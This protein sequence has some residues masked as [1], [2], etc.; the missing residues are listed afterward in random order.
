MNNEE[1]RALPAGG[2]I[3]DKKSPASVKGLHV[4]SR[5]E[6]KRSYML[7]YKTRTGRERRPKIGSFPDITIAEARRRAKI[8]L[9][10][11]ATGADPSGDWQ[12]T[13]SE[14]T[15]RDL[16][17]RTLSTHWS[18]QQYITSG[19]RS[20]V[21]LLW[22]KHI[23][24]AFGDLRISELTLSRIRTWHRSFESSPYAG[25]RSL[26][27]LSR[28][29]TTAEEDE[30]IRPGSNPCRLVKRH[31][32]RTRSRYATAEELRQLIPIL[33][34]E[35]ARHPNGVAFLWVLLLT[36][37]RPRALE[38]ATWDQLEIITRDGRRFGVLRFAGK[39][40]AKT[41]HDEVVILPEFALQ[42]VEKL[43]RRLNNLLLNSKMPTR[44][45]REIRAEMGCKDLWARDFRRTFATIAMSS[46]VNASLVGE[47]LNHRST[48]TT[49]IYA[50]LNDESRVM[51]ATQTAKMIE[52][53]I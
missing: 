13:R 19:Y 22:N 20:D 8:I 24:P 47:L 25:N 11:V 15:I 3:W 14:P 43:P 21:I 26:S 32:E 38:R 2:V 34:R 44:L 39:S 42:M 52:Q 31:Q 37:S 53:M 9:D 23:A 35:Y 29:L 40:T 17:Q 10:Q 45:W 28:I 27:V 41:G 4:R 18:D 51:A 5:G 16:Y 30:V 48:Q 7:Y 36:G 6:N 50:K 1:I 49:K 33:Q 12:T 46:G